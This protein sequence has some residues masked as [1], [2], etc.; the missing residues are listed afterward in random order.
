MRKISIYLNIILLVIVV[1]QSF[2]LG[3]V[4]EEK[5]RLA[6]NQDALLSDIQ[7]YK[8]EAGNN[9]ASVQKLELSRSE[10]KQ[11]CTELVK[12]V[13]E[14][15]L[16]VKRLQAASTTVSKTEVAIKTPVRDSI[17]YRE[18]PDTVKRINW[19]D[20][21]VE[22][23]GMIDKGIFS[24]EIRSTD[25]LIQIIHRIPRKFLFFRWGTKA[26]RQ[27]MINKNPHSRIIYTEY[28]ELKRK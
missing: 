15:N 20:P 14:L 12:T 10:L 3:N 5:R 25:T 6:N 28:I 21:W 18:R 16:K 22:L 13:D 24:G 17:V 26:I 9:A 2:W 7:F 19:K 1:S 8:T 11:H 27:E 23:D 4:R